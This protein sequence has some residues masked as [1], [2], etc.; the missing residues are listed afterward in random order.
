MK[1]KKTQTKISLAGVD[2]G[3]MAQCNMSI[4]EIPHREHPNSKIPPLWSVLSYIMLQ[5]GHSNPVFG[6]IIDSCLR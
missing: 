6:F 2:L 1:G 5:Y 3:V 4:N